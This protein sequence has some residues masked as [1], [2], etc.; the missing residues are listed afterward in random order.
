MILIDSRIQLD[1]GFFISKI[2]IFVRGNVRLFRNV[3]KNKYFGF[4]IQIQD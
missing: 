2:Q 3:A 4:Q 1:N